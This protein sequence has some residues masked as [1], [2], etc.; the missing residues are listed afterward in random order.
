MTEIRLYIEGGGDKEGKARLRQAFATF[1]GELNAQARSRRVRW[2]I[3]LCGSRNQTYEDF[4]LALK[5]H[6]DAFNLLLVDAERPVEGSP[7]A[8]L[9]APP[10]GD[11]WDLSHVGDDQ[12]QLM[13][14][15]M[16]SWF[17]ADSKVLADFYGQ[18]FAG[19]AL[20]KNQKVEQIEKS[21]IMAALAKATRATRKGEYHKM[22]HSPLLLERLDPAKVRA[23]A[24]HCD[25][26]WTTVQEKLGSTA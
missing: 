10:P 1:L 5:T 26:L 8:H 20:P 14:Q 19:A 24:P 11:E 22:R 23:R 15:V 16:E 3:I 21:A 6:P 13:V 25:R 12:C 2:Q 7:R 9:Q 4:L 18:G 17:L